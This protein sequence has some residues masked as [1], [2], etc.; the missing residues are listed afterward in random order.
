MERMRGSDRLAQMVPC[1]KAVK[2]PALGASAAIERSV[3][4]QVTQ[5]GTVARR[6]GAAYEGA[7]AAAV[8][9]RK[10]TKLVRDGRERKRVLEDVDFE[11]D[12]GEIV[13]LRGPSGSGKTTLLGVAGT[14]LLPTTGEVWIGGEATS[15]L[16]DEQRAEVRRKNVGFVFQDVQLVDGMSALDNVLLP[17]VPDGIAQRDRDAASKLLERFDVGAVAHTDVRRLSG[18]EKQRVALARALLRDPKLLLFDE[19]TSHLDEDRAKDFHASVR[20][21][22]AEGRAVLLATHDA[23]VAEQVGA[24]RTLHL[25]SGRLSVGPEE[26]G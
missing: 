12:A 9:V 5:V 24:K 4:Y 10:V 20:E 2:C 13:V 8:A 3:G 19:P 11:I 21:L 26:T 23:R 17:C 6:R 15:R 22:A 7:M 18:G 1:A 16:R 25:A 14:M